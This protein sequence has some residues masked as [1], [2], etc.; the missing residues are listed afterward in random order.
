MFLSGRPDLSWLHDIKLDNFLQCS[1][2]LA[3]I[4]GGGIDDF[5]Q[6]K[7]TLSIQKLSLLATGREPETTTVQDQL[8]YLLAFQ[9]QLFEEN[10]KAM[11]PRELINAVQNK[12]TLSKDEQREMIASILENSTLILRPEQISEVEKEVGVE[13]ETPL[14]F[15]AD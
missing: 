1:Q 14:N 7:T 2:T 6:M 11:T 10:I 5:D 8:R 13:Q 12:S 4:S 15:T 9:E 3:S